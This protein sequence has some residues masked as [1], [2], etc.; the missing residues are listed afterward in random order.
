MVNNMNTGFNGSC[1]MAKNNKTFSDLQLFLILTKKYK[2]DV[3]PEIP[4][5]NFST[6]YQQLLKM[7]S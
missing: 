4:V 1:G 6:I 5:K 2:T 7:I 3:L